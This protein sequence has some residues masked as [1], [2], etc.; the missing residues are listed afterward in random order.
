MKDSE[1]IK[2]LVELAESLKEDQTERGKLARKQLSIYRSIL[3]S[4]RKE[5]ALEIFKGSKGLLR[6]LKKGE[7]TKEEF[8]AK[9]KY[10]KQQLKEYGPLVKELNERLKECIQNKN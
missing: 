2:Q 3:R 7:I 4:E 1:R 8:K 10:A 9:I 6:K 5:E